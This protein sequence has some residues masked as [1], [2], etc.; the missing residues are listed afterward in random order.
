MQVN[1]P[2]SKLNYFTRSI[3]SA[4]KCIQVIK[5]IKIFRSVKNYKVWI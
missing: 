2:R 3:G 4:N 1:S 5:N